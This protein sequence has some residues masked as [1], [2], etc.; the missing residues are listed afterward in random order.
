MKSSTSLPSTTEKSTELS[1]SLVWIQDQLAQA[2]FP[3]STR[4]IEIALMQPTNSILDPH[5]IAKIKQLDRTWN[6]MT[7]RQYSS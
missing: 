1:M 3:T 5:L 2:G 4:M 6:S 7:R